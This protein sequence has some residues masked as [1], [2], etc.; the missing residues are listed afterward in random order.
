[1]AEFGIDTFQH[2]LPKY[3]L[4]KNTQLGFVVGTAAGSIH[5]NT[6]EGHT[7]VPAIRHVN[8]KHYAM[9]FVQLFKELDFPTYEVIAGE[10][11]P[12]LVHEVLAQGASRLV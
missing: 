12:A 3:I 8:G 10:A 1:M 4:G 2:I 5:S 7:V 6:Q 11:S 9:A